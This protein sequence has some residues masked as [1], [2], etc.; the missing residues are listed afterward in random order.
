MA[1]Q[2]AGVYR[3]ARGHLCGLT[4]MLPYLRQRLFAE[5]EG[6][7]NTDRGRYVIT[8]DRPEWPGWLDHLRSQHSATLVDQQAARGLFLTPTRWPPPRA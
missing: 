7:P 3:A 5:F 2:F 8:P 4:P 6:A 1:V